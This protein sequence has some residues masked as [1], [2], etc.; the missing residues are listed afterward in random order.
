MDAIPILRA[1]RME[2]RSAPEARS[3]R[4]ALLRDY[5]EENWPSMDLCAEMLERDL[6]R[7][8]AGHLTF[9]DLRPRFRSRLQRLPWLGRRHAA[10]NAD[11][12]LNRFWDFPRHLR[13]LAGQADCFH[14]V[15]HSYSQLIHV[16]PPNRAGVYCHDLDTFRCLLDPAQE[17]RP[18]WFRAMVR[19]TLA[20]LRKAAVV[21]H[22]TQVVRREIEQRQLVDPA[23]LVHAPYGYS[24]EYNPDPA[25][26]PIAEALW[27]RLGG[28]PYLLHVGSCIPRKRID[29][30]LKTFARLRQRLPG[31]QLVK[32]GGDWSAE[33]QALVEQHGIG[34]DL[35]HLTG[36]ERTTLAALYCRASLVLMPSAAEGFG[37]P[38]LEALACRGPGAG[39]RF[40][41]LERGRR[42]SGVLCPG[43]CHRCLGR[44]R[45]GPAATAGQR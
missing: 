30:L 4:L 3:L 19:R 16:L 36:L 10:F 43:R 2:K 25:P 13:R 7:D 44:G 24:E 14:V 27:Q 17:R 18:Y 35:V 41:G 31:L 15:D 26:C 23:R 8:H 40:A 34:P 21:F 29:V 1:N 11:R 5:P 28:R 38:V 6:R 42:A 33:Q 20:G 22:S 45:S 12:L 37:L 9:V 32:V 39:Q